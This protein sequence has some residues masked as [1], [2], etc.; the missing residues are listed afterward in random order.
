MGRG[1][2]ACDYIRGWLDYCLQ[3]YVRLLGPRKD[4]FPTGD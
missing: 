2:V 1:R 3:A 4:L